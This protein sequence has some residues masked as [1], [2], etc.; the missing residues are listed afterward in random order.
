MSVELLK[1]SVSVDVEVMP[2]PL[3]DVHEVIN[4]SILVNIT[5]LL[6]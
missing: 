2:G 6:H 3:V 1:E 5:S 4:I